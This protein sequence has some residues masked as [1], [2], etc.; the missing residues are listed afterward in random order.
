M[1][2][3]G[4][5]WGD[6]HPLGKFVAL[7]IFEEEGCVLDLGEA[8]WVGDYRVVENFRVVLS[9][10]VVGTVLLVDPCKSFKSSIWHI[11]LVK[12]PADSFV[13]E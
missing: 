2:V 3:G 11:F 10:V 1:T 8:V 9:N 12:S 4:H 6:E 5:V 7:E 13:F